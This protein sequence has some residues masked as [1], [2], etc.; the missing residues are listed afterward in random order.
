[1]ATPSNIRGKKVIG[2]IGVDIGCQVD[3]DMVE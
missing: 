3:F 1:M 2:D